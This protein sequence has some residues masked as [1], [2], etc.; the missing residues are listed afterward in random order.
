MAETSEAEML[1]GRNQRVTLAEII[2]ATVSP[3]RIHWDIV[4]V[5]SVAEAMPI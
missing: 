2:D 5:Q 1:E 4:I 3:L